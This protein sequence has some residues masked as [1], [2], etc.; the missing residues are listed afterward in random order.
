MKISDK[1]NYVFT[2][3]LMTD[4]FIKHNSFSEKRNCEF[5]ILYFSKYT[6]DIVCE[7]INCFSVVTNISPDTSSSLTEFCLIKF[8]NNHQ[9][10]CNCNASL[11]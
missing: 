4:S 7:H 3:S 2:D 11:K 10:F 9:F 5:S 1:S 6:V 8:S